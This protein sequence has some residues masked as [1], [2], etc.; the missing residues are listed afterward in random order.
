M[1]KV[2]DKIAQAIIKDKKAFNSIKKSMSW[3]LSDILIEGQINLRD[4]IRAIIIQELPNAFDMWL[5][6]GEEE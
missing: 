1:D 5:A 3:R 4:E 2:A 6:S